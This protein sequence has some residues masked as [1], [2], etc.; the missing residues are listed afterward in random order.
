MKACKDSDVATLISLKVSNIF[1]F[2][3][4]AAQL[5]ERFF[6]SSVLFDS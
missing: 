2:Y 1:V 5:Y 4:Q 3:Q 6:P